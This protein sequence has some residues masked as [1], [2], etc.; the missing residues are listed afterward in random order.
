MDR[1]QPN[2]A[3]V[4][5]NATE[6]GV[7][8]KIGNALRSPEGKI[9]EAALVMSI[10]ISALTG[11]AP[12][13]APKPTTT[14]SQ[15]ATPTPTETENPYGAPTFERSPIPASLESTLNMPL[16]EYQQ[17]SV[18]ERLTLLSWIID[19]APEFSDRYVRVSGH[20][21]TAIPEPAISD[22]PSQIYAF[23]RGV[24]NMSL[25]FDD[26]DGNID[27]NM[28]EK[29]LYA[30]SAPSEWDSISTDVAKIANMPHALD[31]DTVAL[32]DGADIFPDS[33]ISNT[34]IYTGPS[35]V[36]SMDIA[37]VSDSGTTINETYQFYT[38]T[39]YKG[40]E[41]GAWILAYNSVR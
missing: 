40:E 5:A 38:Y 34:S 33:I 24:F 26:G 10:G 27:L 16:E 20:D 25:T 32:Q 6:A 22:T 21:W 3:D 30:T 9:V 12:D 13:E 36:P 14:Q 37:R 19:Y 39:N 8:K 11:C 17:L 18:E 15:E 23:E 29:A 4:T 7:F 41:A 31:V 2:P 1:R 28:V 35:G